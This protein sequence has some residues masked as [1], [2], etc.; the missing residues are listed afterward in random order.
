VLHVRIEDALVPD[1]TVTG[2]QDLLPLLGVSPYLPEARVLPDRLRA[3]EAELQPVVVLRI[4]AGGDHDARTVQGAG[5]E[6]Q[7]VGGRQ[8]E[9]HDVDV[10]RRGSFGQR[11]CEIGRGQAAVPPHEDLRGPTPRGERG[12]DPPHEVGVQFIG[13]DTAN[14]VRLED[15]GEVHRSHPTDGLQ[16]TSG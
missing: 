1:R 13:D 7:E 11:R 8:S 14:V 2:S 3:R 15:A 4:V 12:A 16:R 9:V 5:G 6:V 10:P